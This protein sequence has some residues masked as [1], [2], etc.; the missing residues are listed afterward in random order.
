MP[1]MSFI[2]WF[3]MLFFVEVLEFELV[4]ML[5]RLVLLPLESLH[6]PS[7]VLGIFKIGSH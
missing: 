6:H 5:A 3:I 4:L 7:F 2:D 1:I